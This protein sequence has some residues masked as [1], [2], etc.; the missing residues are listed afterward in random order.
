MNIELLI[1]KFYEG[2]STPEEERLLTKYF[3]NVENVDERWK[4]EQ[5]LFRLLH[6]TQIQVPSGVSKRLEKSIICHSALDA[7]SPENVASPKVSQKSLFRKKTWYYWISSAAAIALL[8]IGIFFAVRKPAQPKMADTFSNPE[9]AA[10]V[11]QQTL[12]FMSVQ[13]NKG[14]NRVTDAE[15]K[16]EEVNQLLNKHLNK[17]KL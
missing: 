3:L 13:L 8:C 2:V 11:A 15:L 9:E 16:F 6:A 12:A 17:S 1:E 5:Q 10:L 4:D 7:E 14:L